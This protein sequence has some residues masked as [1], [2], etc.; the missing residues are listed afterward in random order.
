MPDYRRYAEIMNS[1]ARLDGVPEPAVDDTR[2]RRFFLKF[3]NDEDFLYSL[4]FLCGLTIHLDSQQ[5]FT[6]AWKARTGDNGTMLEVHV[7]NAI[8]EMNGDFVREWL[9]YRTSIARNA[10]IPDHV[11]DYFNTQAPRKLIMVFDSFAECFNENKVHCLALFHLLQ[12]NQPNI[13]Q[14]HLFSQVAEYDVIEKLGRIRLLAPN[15]YNHLT[16][17]EACRAA[18]RQVAQLK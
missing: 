17:D 13:L 1:A 7:N 15:Y 2:E 12:R 18:G 6:S 14:E 8:L 9:D 16:R 10:E 5:P 4:H 11:I 3:T